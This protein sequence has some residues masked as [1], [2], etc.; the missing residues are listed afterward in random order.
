MKNGVIVVLV[1]ALGI[2]FYQN[3]GLRGQLSNTLTR[4]ENTQ[5]VAIDAQ[6]QMVGQKQES[7]AATPVASVAAAA[8]TTASASNRNSAPSNTRAQASP[9]PSLRLTDLQ[10]ESQQLQQQIRDLSSTNFDQAIQQKQ[11]DLQ[12]LQNQMKTK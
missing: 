7:V 10:N 11:A 5:D 9:S 3:R 12:A 1:I 6:N 4:L 8:T 2:L